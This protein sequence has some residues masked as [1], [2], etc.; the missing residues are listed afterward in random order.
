[1]DLQEATIAMAALMKGEADFYREHLKDAKPESP[2]ELERHHKALKEFEWLQSNTREFGNQ[3]AA[4]PNFFDIMESWKI[5][6]NGT[7]GASKDSITEAISTDDVDGLIDRCGNLAI[8]IK[9]YIKEKGFIICGMSAGEDGWDIAVRCSEKNS[10]VLCED[11]YR[12][13][14]RALEVKLITV[15]RR[16][17]GHCLPG[18]YSW[19]DAFRILTILGL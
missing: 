2:E 4:N 1:M 8:G 3:L 10:R 9:G 11:V 19:D 18:L 7:E 17:A 15:S 16:F 12:R 14:F 13:F 5:Y 6:I